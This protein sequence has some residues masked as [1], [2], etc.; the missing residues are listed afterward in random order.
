MGEV[1]CPGSSLLITGCYP[2]RK[3]NEN[4]SAYFFHLIPEKANLRGCPGGEGLCCTLLFF[5]FVTANY[6]KWGRSFPAFTVS[7]PR[8]LIRHWGHIMKNRAVL[9]ALVTAFVVAGCARPE[10]TVLKPYQLADGTRLQDVVTIGADTSGT[11]P[12]LTHVKTFRLGGKRG[13]EIVADGVGSGPSFA[14][15][16]AGAAISGVT[17]GVAGGLIANAVRDRRGG[18][19]QVDT[20]DL[21]QNAS[22]PECICKLNPKTAG[23]NS[24]YGN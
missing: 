15:T 8:G 3:L 19:Q 13:A 2:S 23:C 20:C 5:R 16:A 4:R 21:V 9:T 24:A 14:T 17:G 1:W 12:V 10:T 6:P 22:L 18:G 7:G 11:A